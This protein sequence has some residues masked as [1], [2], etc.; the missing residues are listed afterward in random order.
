[1]RENSAEKSRPL[2]KANVPISQSNENENS[3]IR[4]NLTSTQR[5]QIRL[6]VLRYC[7]AADQF[8][9]AGSLLLQFVRSEGFRRLNRE[10]LETE[11]IYLGDKGL[12]ARVP[13]EISPENSLWRIT[14]A[15]RDFLAKLNPNDA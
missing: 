6:S 13:K 1:M 11:L 4:M 12:L 10:H 15:G 9:L 8:G 14:A 5:E 3:N 2:D 7:E